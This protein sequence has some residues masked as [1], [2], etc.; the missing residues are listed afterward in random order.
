MFLS[1][2]WNHRLTR[3]TQADWGIYLTVKTKQGWYVHLANKHHIAL[4][5]LLLH[6]YLARKFDLQVRNKETKFD[7]DVCQ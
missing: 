3:A 6:W 7:Q 5:K 4:L 2:L 1:Q